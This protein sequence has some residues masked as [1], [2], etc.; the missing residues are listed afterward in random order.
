MDWVTTSWISDILRPR[1]DDSSLLA[2][3]ASMYNVVSG[4]S[5]FKFDI[6][7]PDEYISHLTVAARD[8][9]VDILEWIIGK[10][11]EVFPGENPDYI[12][13]ECICA[14]IEGGKLDCIKLSCSIIEDFPNENIVANIAELVV[15]CNN[16][17]YSQGRIEILEWLF[18]FEY[19][20]RNYDLCFS[21]AK[22]GNLECLK[23]VH[24]RGCIIE[25]ISSWYGGT[26]ID[27]AIRNG[28]VECL[29]YA[30]ENGVQFSFVSM[31]NAAK[32]RRLDCYMYCRENN[33]PRVIYAVLQA[34]E[35]GWPEPRA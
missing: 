18:D 7:D 16:R 17:L 15:S 34:L 6:N 10:R 29:R 2:F 12:L 11:S 27:Q 31:F 1:L 14:A 9:H 13:T 32:F 26:V 5:K 19:D 23:F 21:A 28:H 25:G 20:M 3:K 8:G 33:A 24:E 22:A 4:R 30:H 35:N